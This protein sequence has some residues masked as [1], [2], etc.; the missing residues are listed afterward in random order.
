[1]VPSNWAMPSLQQ[2][3]LGLLVGVQLADGMEV[4]RQQALEAARALS[5]FGAYVW[6]AIYHVSES[7]RRVVRNGP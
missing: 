5:A 4:D 3:K 1:M 2:V 6:R 7:E